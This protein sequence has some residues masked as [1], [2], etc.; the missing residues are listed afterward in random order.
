M[1][2]KQ[3][4]CRLKRNSTGIQAVD[5]NGTS[6]AGI[7]PTGNVFKLSFIHVTSSENLHWWSTDAVHNLPGWYSI[8]VCYTKFRFGDALL[9]L[10]CK[11]MC[12]ACM[13]HSWVIVQALRWV[14]EN[15]YT[16]NIKYILP[17]ESRMSL[18]LP[19]LRHSIHVPAGVAWSIPSTSLHS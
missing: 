15:C 14:V 18:A 2:I 17:Y 4:Q 8:G 3:N 16:R 10:C 5:C 11:K 7:P 9:Y 19:R 13:L 1:G 12:E 6:G